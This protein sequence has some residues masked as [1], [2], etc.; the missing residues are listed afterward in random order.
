MF[1]DWLLKTHKIKANAKQFLKPLGLPKDS[2][3]AVNKDSRKSGTFFKM[4][5]LKA[6]GIISN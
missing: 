3:V 6:A 5:P 1:E 4:K 2:F